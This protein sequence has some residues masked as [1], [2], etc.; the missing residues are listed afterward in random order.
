MRWRWLG[1][2]AAT[3]ATW[4]ATAA[5]TS[6]VN[7]TQASGI[8]F[9]GSLNTIEQAALCSFDIV[10]W[11]PFT[12]SSGWNNGQVNWLAFSIGTVKFANSNS[13]IVKAVVGNK[14]DTFGA[15]SS[16]VHKRYVGNGANLIKQILQTSWLETERSRQFGYL[17]HTYFEITFGNIVMKVFDADFG[18]GGGAILI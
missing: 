17:G 2:V 8:T 10:K 7:W 5:T 16:V 3:T 1:D 4:G 9:A 18:F 15:S 12:S 13:C 11:V 14:G 6:L